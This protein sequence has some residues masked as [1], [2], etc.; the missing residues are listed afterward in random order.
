M[1]GIIAMGTNSI[2][3]LPHP[4]GSGH[5]ARKS[6]V[7]GKVA[8]VDVGE[9]HITIL[10]YHYQSIVQGTWGLGLAPVF[11]NYCVFHSLTENDGDSVS[12]KVFLAAGTYTLS[13]LFGTMNIHMGITDVDIDDVEIASW[14][15]YAVVSV[16]NIRKTDT[17]NVIATDG[18]KTLTVRVDGKNP[19]SD[20]YLCQLISIALW[21]TS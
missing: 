18:V 3:G 8:A 13:I 10:P 19:S 4:T 11:V 20:K 1:S 5:A 2:I 12:Y 6:Y 17:G 16:T 9:G 14:D 15:L 7:D 21:R